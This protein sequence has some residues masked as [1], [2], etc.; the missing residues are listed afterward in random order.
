MATN[1]PLGT[2]ARQERL[3]A[4]RSVPPTGASA[5]RRLVASAL[6]H[7][8]H[9][10]PVPAIQPRVFSDVVRRGVSAGTHPSRRA[11]AAEMEQKGRRLPQDEWLPPE[12]PCREY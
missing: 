2:S 9:S 12:L 7:Q 11:G 3:P 8:G 5:S 1:L 10:S 4:R 6:V